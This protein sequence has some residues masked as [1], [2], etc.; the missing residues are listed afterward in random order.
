MPFTDDLSLL[1]YNKGMKPTYD[2]L[3][4]LF[5]S[6]MVSPTALFSPRHGQAEANFLVKCLVLWLC[7]IVSIYKGGPKYP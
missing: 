1:G 4:S 7:L 5:E 3:M 2:C 6:R